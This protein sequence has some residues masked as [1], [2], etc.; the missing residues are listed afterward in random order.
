M[1]NKKKKKIHRRKRRIPLNELLLLYQ[2][3]ITIILPNGTHKTMSAFEYKT[4]KKPL[5][6]KKKQKRNKKGKK[7]G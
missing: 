2:N 5:K 4:G 1:I 7:R 6:P 3:P